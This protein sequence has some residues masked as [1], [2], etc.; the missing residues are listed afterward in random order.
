[1]EIT[2]IGIDEA[3]LTKAEYRSWL[4]IER[5]DAFLQKRGSAYV[6]MRMPPEVL[7]TRKSK[8]V[9]EISR[10]PDVLREANVSHAPI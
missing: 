10:S 8:G 1:M 4:S 5:S 9:V 2:S 3:G 6:I 7:T